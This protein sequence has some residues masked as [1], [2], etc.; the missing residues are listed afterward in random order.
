MR[1]ILVF[2]M[3]AIVLGGCSSSTLPQPRTEEE[4]RLF[5]PVAMKLDTFSKVKDWSGG[6]KP[7]GV[8]ALVEFDDRSGD[9]TKSAGTVLFE[10]YDYRPNWPDPRGARMVNPWTASLSSYDQQK[11]HWERASGAYIFRLACDGLQWNHNYVL[12]ATF[13]SSPGNRFFSQII[14]RAQSAENRV[15]PTTNQSESG[16]GRRAPQP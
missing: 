3:M 9:R 1:R 4:N 2:A 15:E 7:E 6:G 16:L 14:L 8:E 10:L 11:A 13:E 12:S 5:G